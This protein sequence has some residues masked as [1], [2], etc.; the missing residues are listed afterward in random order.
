MDLALNN[1]QRL[2]CHKTQTTKP[3]NP[4]QS[5]PRSND[6]EGVLHTLQISRTGASPSDAA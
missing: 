5:E 1:V 6:N 4:G 2:I 3:T